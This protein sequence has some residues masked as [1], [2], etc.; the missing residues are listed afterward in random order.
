MEQEFLINWS[1]Q[2][3]VNDWKYPKTPQIAF[4]VLWENSNIII[5]KQI[6]PL[7]T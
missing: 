5:W 6:S 1:M 4:Q 3:F 2:S 7:N